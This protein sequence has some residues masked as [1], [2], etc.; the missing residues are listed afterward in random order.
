LLAR[1][2]GPLGRHRLL[3]FFALAYAITWPGWWLVAAGSPSG[4]FLGYFGAAI[5]AIL[6]AAISSDREGLRELQIVP[7]TFGL[8]FPFRAHIL[9]LAASAAV[10]VIAAGPEP[11]RTSVQSRPNPF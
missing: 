7:V 1:I 4:A 10:I 9:V 3:T 11:T 6:V 5:A 8:G 2:A